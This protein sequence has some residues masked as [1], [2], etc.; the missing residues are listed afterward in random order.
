MS[1]RW[2]RG[3][4]LI[5]CLVTGAVL[6][7]LFQ[8]IDLVDVIHNI[9]GINAEWFFLFIAISLGTSFF[10]LLRYELLLGIG[11]VRT[12]LFPLYLIVLVR[13][14]CSDLLPAR[15]GTL[16][17]VVLV[18]ERLKVPLDLAVSTFSFAFLFDLLGLVPIV[19]VAAAVVAKDPNLPLGPIVL[20]A[21][22]LSVFIVVFMNRL[23]VMIQWGIRIVNRSILSEVRK[24]RLEKFARRIIEQI[25]TTRRAGLF[26]PTLALSVL[27]RLGKYAT[28]YCLLFA[29]LQP[30]GYSLGELPPAKI[31]FGLTAS[32]LSASLPIS[33]IAGFGLYQGTWSTVFQLLGFPEQIAKVTSLSHHGTT[34]LWGYGIGLIALLL[35][36]MPGVTRKGDI[37]SFPPAS[38]RRIFG[39]SFVML[40]LLSFL[41]V[42]C[43]QRVGA[44]RPVQYGESKP[45]D[46]ELQSRGRFLEKLEGRISFD[47]NRSGTFGVY[48]LN[49]QGEIST[50]VDDPSWHEVLP[51]PSPNGDWIVF[52]RAKSADRNSVS[53]IWRVRP[54]GTALSR[55]AVN[56]T[57][58][59]FSSDGG[60]IYFERERRKVMTVPLEGGAEHEVF[61]G[62]RAD[63]FG[64]FLVVK[65][66]IS[67]DVTKI[68]FT[69]DKEERWSAFIA[70]LVTGE[71]RKIGSGC[72][73]TFRPGTDEI[74]WVQERG[75][76]ERSGIFLFSD[77][78]KKV[79]EDSDAPWGHEY[80]PTFSP[81]GAVLLFA[82]SP[83]K[84]H[85][86][87]S[88]HYQLFG[89][90]LHSGERVR[91]TFDGFTNR[92]PRVLPYL[93]EKK[94][95]LL[96]APG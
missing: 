1:E 2:K 30:L 12:P 78:A 70:N 34:Q 57:A 74:A 22:F 61:P 90:D 68:A 19:L 95:H 5:S 80:F 82:A 75:A 62:P 40:G 21:V 47:S 93:L 77:G 3:T 29:L 17:Y 73:P 28:L 13:N 39:L 76:L 52:A 51:S 89:K 65:P 23:D 24:E 81:S 84:Q 72:E 10:R 96:N 14:L 86:H 31:F 54:D 32:E 79:L 55:V 4:V 83:P 42:V 36:Y 8:S 15:L 53:D 45:T 7:F 69:T 59:V 18:N 92:W 67:S 63:Q 20:G 26:V 16:S 44:E 87:S 64:T 33:G 11:G 46:A 6:Y 27:I 38:L 71:F 49:P 50:V 91:L 9:R 43:V 85:D 94:Q 41:L 48:L 37:Q 56:G 35:L 25:H 88:A 60:A 58:P 66:R